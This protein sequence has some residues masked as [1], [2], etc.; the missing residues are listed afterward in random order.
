MTFISLRETAPQ[1]QSP[2]DWQKFVRITEAEARTC[3]EALQRQYPTLLPSICDRQVVPLADM[4]EPLRVT[5]TALETCFK[6]LGKPDHRKLVGDWC[7]KVETAAKSI[8]APTTLVNELTFPACI[9]LDVPFTLYADGHIPS[10]G[11]SEYVGQQFSPMYQ[12]IAKGRKLR[13]PG[14]FAVVVERPTHFN[15]D[16]FGRPREDEDPL[17]KRE[18][19]LWQKGF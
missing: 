4:I 3:L 7:D 11:I 1:R 13:E 17:W 12:A 18:T 8:G 15:E 2:P 16:R 14:N 10:L 6:R 5:I 9:I 19:T